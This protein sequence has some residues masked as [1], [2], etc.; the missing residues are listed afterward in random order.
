MV[1][2]Q[3]LY[4][5]KIKERPPHVVS[6]SNTL[7]VK[8]S[9]DFDPSIIYTSEESKTMLKFKKGSLHFFLLF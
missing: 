3:L 6:K 1:E 4:F 5:Q 7:L 2:E 8:A 9:S